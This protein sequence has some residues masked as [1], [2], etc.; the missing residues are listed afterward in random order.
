MDEERAFKRPANI[1]IPKAATIGVG[2]LV[3]GRTEGNL[4]VSS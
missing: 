1:T 4:D 2:A 3:G